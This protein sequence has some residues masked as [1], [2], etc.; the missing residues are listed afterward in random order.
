VRRYGGPLISVAQLV[1]NCM[2]TAKNATS[3]DSEERREGVCLK[4][5]KVYDNVLD[6]GHNYNVK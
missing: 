6:K 1:L 3:E 2:H 4:E 5:N